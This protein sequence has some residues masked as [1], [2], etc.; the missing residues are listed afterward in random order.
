MLSSP[1]GRGRHAELVGRLEVVEDLPPVALV[2]GR[3]PGGTRPR[4]SGRRS[5]GDTR[6]RGRAGSR[7]WRW[8]G[9]WR[10]TFPGLSSTR[11]PDLAA[12]VAEGGEGLVLGVVDQD[13]AVGQEEDS[14]WRCSPVRFQPARPELPADLKGDEGFAG[15]GGHGE[16][17]AAIARRGRFDRPVDGDFLVVAQALAAEVVIG[18][19]ELRGDFGRKRHAGKSGVARVRPGWETR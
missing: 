15:A 1:R 7:P 19:E 12:G 13:V 2:A 14:G 18:G 11:P 9:R 6:G 8:P 17:D 5:R 4:R 10:S 16:Q 3:C